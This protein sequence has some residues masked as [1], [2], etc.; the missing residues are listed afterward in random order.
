M[1][2]RKVWQEIKYPEEDRLQLYR[3]RLVHVKTERNLTSQKTLSLRAAREHFAPVVKLTTPMRDVL[4][5]LGLRVERRLLRAFIERNKQ[6]KRGKQKQR[7][8]QRG[9]KQ[10]EEESD[11]EI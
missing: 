10:C 3:L 11:L 9:R 5:L 8:R 4:L 7:K 6:T 2:C 1:I